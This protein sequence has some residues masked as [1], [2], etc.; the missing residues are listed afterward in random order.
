MSVLLDALKKAALEKQK[1]EFTPLVGVENVS[2]S[3]DQDTS[4]NEI[5]DTEGKSE[6]ETL[7]NTDSKQTRSPASL[8]DQSSLQSEHAHKPA[9]NENL[10]SIESEHTETSTHSEFEIEKP[11]IEDANT[12]NNLPGDF[13][14][15]ILSEDGSHTAAATLN[16]NPDREIQEQNILTGGTPDEAISDEKVPLELDLEID[17]DFLETLENDPVEVDPTD[18]PKPTNNQNA[19]Y[20]VKQGVTA[21]QEHYQDYES[22]KNSNLHKDEEIEQNTSSYEDIKNTQ[23]DAINLL[24]EKIPQVENPTITAI[25][26]NENREEAEQSS[27]IYNENKTKSHFNDLR[28]SRVKEERLRKVKL[29]ILYSMVLSASIATVVLYYYFGIMNDKSHFI[30]SIPIKNDTDVSIVEQLNQASEEAIIDPIQD[31]PRPIQEAEITT[32][33]VDTKDLNSLSTTVTRQP[34][35]E[36]KSSDLTTTKT[37][38]GSKSSE[39][40]D[41]QPR[42]RSAQLSS[43]KS[44]SNS[45]KNTVASETLIQKGEPKYDPLYGAIHKGYAAFNNGK[46]LEAEK[47]YQKAL[48][49]SPANRDALLG[50]AAVS[51]AKKHYQS[52]LNYYQQRLNSAPKDTFALAGM[53]SIAAIENPSPALMSQVNQIVEDNPG[54]AHLYFIKGSLLASDA[55]W[56]AAQSEFFKAWSLDPNKAEYVFNLAVSLDHL[57]QHEQ[58]LRFYKNALNLVSLGGTSLNYKSIQARIV[59]LENKP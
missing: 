45:N 25:T 6:T 44:V 7:A 27:T 28:N 23:N 58:A 32:E 21:E 2:T 16:V 48:L 19:D 9:S 53:L 55:R 11:N 52:A 40:V 17:Q 4:A 1:R 33:T 5:I 59:Q 31:Q 10:A 12:D 34:T 51:L 29:I 43:E 8:D 57:N 3:T 37:S 54:A 50:M 18:A 26:E 15:S 42:Q 38:R 20:N 36:A 22:A 46:Y 13:D 39:K 49:I 30:N 47:E 41:T 35:K 14:P 24:E 56:K